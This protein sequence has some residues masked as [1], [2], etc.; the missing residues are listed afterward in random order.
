MSEARQSSVVDAAELTVE[1]GGFHFQMGER[2]DD[3]RIFSRPVE[4]S[5]GQKLRPALI[6]ASGHAITVELYLMQPLRPRG[7]L[8]DQFGELRRDELRERD[9]LTRGAHLDGLEG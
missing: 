8:L 2:L 1:I 3:A 9:A 7:R 5:S 4:P 6:V